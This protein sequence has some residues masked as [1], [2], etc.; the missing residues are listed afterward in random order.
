MRELKQRLQRAAPR[1]PL[2]LVMDDCAVHV[3]GMVLQQ[4]RSLGIALVLVPARCKWLSQP[5]DTHVFA[6][7]KNEIR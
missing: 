4:C 1:R 6:K 5:L 3:I 2:Q 7:L